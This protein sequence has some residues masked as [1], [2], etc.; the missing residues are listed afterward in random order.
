MTEFFSTGCLGY[1]I[2]YYI[3]PEDKEI[4]QELREIR[5]QTIDL[6]L[7]V[8]RDELARQFQS[9]FGT[10]SGQWPKAVFKRR[11]SMP[12]KSPSVILSSD[13]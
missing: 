9:D 6:M 10:V 3:D 8:S 4:L 13:G 7:S 1:P 11:A 5:L 12:M 2:L